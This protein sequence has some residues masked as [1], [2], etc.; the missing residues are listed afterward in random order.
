MEQETG[1]PRAPIR[2]IYTGDSPIFFRALAAVAQSHGGIRIIGTS[3]PGRPTLEDVQSL[4]PQIVLVDLDT[5]ELKGI[6]LVS[7]LR[8]E[9]P[10]MG[11][12]AVALWDEPAYRTA[13][14]SAGADGFVAKTKLTTQ[15]LP[16]IAAL[17]RVLAE[18]SPPS[19]RDT[20]EA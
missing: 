7:T 14:L 15:L 13:A 12:I 6:E 5:P 9:H 19:G 16:E 17:E 1:T 10:G 11:I 20:G 3:E 18:P 8:R 4:A 2:M